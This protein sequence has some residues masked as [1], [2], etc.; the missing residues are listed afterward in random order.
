MDK[1][2]EVQSKTGIKIPLTEALSGA[3]EVSEVV[4]SKEVVVVLAN[5][6][7]KRLMQVLNRNSFQR[8]K[9]A[10]IEKLQSNDYLYPWVRVL[11]TDERE[12]L[13]YPEQRK[14]G[15][16]WS[17]IKSDLWSQILNGGR[18]LEKIG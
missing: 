6:G 1:R 16:R 8:A 3:E 5:R 4:P 11:L 10:I 17:V 18:V 2:K 7:G 15:R 12:L 13:K 14:F 9:N